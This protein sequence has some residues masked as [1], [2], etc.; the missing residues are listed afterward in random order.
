VE[1]RILGTLDV[2]DGQQSVD[3]SRPKP[4]ALLAML[5]VYANQV[6]SA[7]RLADGLWGE[8]QPP[9]ATNTLQTYVSQLRQALGGERDD[10][11]RIR[12]QA[13]GYVLTVDPERIDAR[14]FERLLAE[15]RRSLE[16]S[17]P[18]QAA[19]RLEAAL[20]LWRGPALAD[21]AGETFASLEA[22]RLQELRL[23]AVE[24]HAYAELALGRHAELV[25]RLQILVAEHPLREGLWGQLMLALYRCSRQAEALR[26]FQT[27]RRYLAEELGIDPGPDL[28]KLEADILAQAPSL[29]YK[30][31]TNRQGGV[32]EAA[33]TSVTAG[34]DPART[35]PPLRVVVADDHPLFREGVRTVL[36][37][38]PAMDVVGEVANGVD[39]VAIVADLQPDVVIMDLHMPALNGIEATRQIVAASPN[40][41]VLILTMFEDDDSVFAAMKAGARGYLLKEGRPDQIVIGVRAVGGGETIFGAPVAKRIMQFFTQPEGRRAMPAFPQLTDR[42]RDVLERVARGA[43]N[44]SIARELY[45][46]HKTIRNH[47]SNIFA[48]LHVA[49]RAEAIVRAREAGLGIR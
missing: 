16:A 46:S 23:A 7:E 10:G 34:P 25:G 38:D 5:V 26:S 3:F 39:A 18:D 27:A 47:V 24:A 13:P 32:A 49:D 36:G 6:V 41:G 8:L 29:A 33:G 2:I 12:T 20:S 40:V 11:V 35:K 9:S 45:L 19:L 44:E 43:N 1:F 14:R 42:E 30:P 28:R 21:F 15:G 31:S 17:E 37:A 4:R 48:K 22:C